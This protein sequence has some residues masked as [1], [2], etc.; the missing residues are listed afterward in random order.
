MRYY[1]DVLQGNYAPR[2]LVRGEFKIVETVIVQNEPSTF[3]AL[4]PA[5][6]LPQPA[7]LIRVEEGVHQVVAVVLRDLERLSLD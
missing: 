3:P 1:R 5:P 6:L 7:L 2:F 4:I